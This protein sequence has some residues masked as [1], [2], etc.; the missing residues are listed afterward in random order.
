MHSTPLAP[1]A[2]LQSL[3]RHFLQGTGLPFSE[4]LPAQRVLDVLAA[5]AVAFR[6][7]LFSPLVTLWTLPLPGRQQ[8]PFLPP[9]RRTSARLP[10][11][12]RTTAL[13]RPYRQLLQGAPMP[14]RGRLGSS[15]S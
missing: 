11:R 2:Q 1:L 8:G 3:R 9:G 15:D 12:P 5:E 10:R 7:R 13:L 14:A 6:D 4:L